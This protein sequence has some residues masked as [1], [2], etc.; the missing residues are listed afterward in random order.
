MKLEDLLVGAKGRSRPLLCLEINPPRGTDVEP[1]LERYKELSGV[2]FVNVTD[3]ALAKVKLSGFI[4]AALFKQRYG[5]EPLVNLSCRDRNVIALQADLLG[6]WSLGIR[7]IVAL[8]GDAVTVGDLPDAKGVF[9]VNSIGL[10]NILASL[11][12]GKDLA[13]VEL[14]GATGYVPGVVVNP[15][16]RNRDAEIRR[17]S[18]KRE[19]GGSY[20]LSQPVF[21]VDHAVEFFQAASATGVDNFV[22]LLPFKT[23]RGFEAVAKIPGIKVPEGVLD[24]VRSLAEDDVARYSIDLACEIAERT[25]PFVRGFHVISGGSPLLAVELCNRLSSWIKSIDE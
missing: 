16:V 20:A 24:R 19:A 13:G 9:E 21:D 25:R 7:S 23:A 8:T 15:N 3:S 12:S 4:F 11:N 2:D 10:L 1:V 14:K 5:I 6:A 22:G 17:L 18:R